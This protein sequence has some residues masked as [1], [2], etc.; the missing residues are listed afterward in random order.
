MAQVKTYNAKSCTVTIT[1][2]DDTTFNVTGLAES[3]FTFE[4]DE[5]YFSTSVGA[6][7]DVVVNEINNDLYTLTMTVQATS[8]Q[9]AALTALKDD[10]EYFAIWV[11]DTSLN[12]KFGGATARVKTM[13]SVEKG[14]EAGDREFSFQVFDGKVETVSEK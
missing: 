14:A 2:S 12:E 6:Q 3:M 5:D 10:R 7:G 13:S 8:P 4:K 11:N 9:L 1:K